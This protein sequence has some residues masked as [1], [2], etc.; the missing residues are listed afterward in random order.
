MK[1]NKPTE[2]AKIVTQSAKDAS[3]KEVTIAKERKEKVFANEEMRKMYEDLKVRR[4]QILRFSKY[5]TLYVNMLC[6]KLI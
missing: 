2:V 5:A 6:D 1:T 3:G 4:K